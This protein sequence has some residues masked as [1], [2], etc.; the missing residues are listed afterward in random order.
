MNDSH[1]FFA[2]HYLEWT[3]QIVNKNR[4]HPSVVMFSTG[5]EIPQKAGRGH[6]Y[7]IARNIADKIRE[8]DPSRP[9]THALCSLWG[10][11]E[12][13]EKER[14]T[15]TAPASEMDYFAEATKITADTTRTGKS[16]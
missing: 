14:Q 9:V 16:P 3:E 5:N 15:D 1:I 2:E 10:N 7:E 4:T 6:G 11:A 13:Y 8:I 12:A